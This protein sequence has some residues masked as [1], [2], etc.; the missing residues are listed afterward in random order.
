V[1][2][3]L[4][5]F[6]LPSCFT[7]FA[8]Q[9]GPGIKAVQKISV[10]ARKVGVTNVSL[11]R[12]IDRKNE[13]SKKILDVIFKNFPIENEVWIQTRQWVINPY[14]EENEILKTRIS[15]LEKRLRDVKKAHA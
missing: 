13:A 7:V 10:F 15:S 1:P 5:L 4:A 6:L 8:L 9:S 14:E 2:V 3:S 12:I 11:Y